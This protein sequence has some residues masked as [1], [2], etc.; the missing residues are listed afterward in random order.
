MT[1]VSDCEWRKLAQCGDLT[2][3]TLMLFDELRFNY[4]RIIK[5]DNRSEEQE[6]LLKEYYYS[7]AY[8]QS[9]LETFPHKILKVFEELKYVRKKMMH[10]INHPE[11]P[12]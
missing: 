3:A 11:R 4:E 12:T 9:F 8:K 5:Y 1:Y 7:V 6:A 10:I 2:K